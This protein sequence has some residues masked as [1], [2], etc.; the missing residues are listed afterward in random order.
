MHIFRPVCSGSLFWQV[1]FPMSNCRKN[2]LVYL[3]LVEIVLY[4]LYMYSFYNIYIFFLYM[5]I[6]RYIFT[7]IYIY[8]HTPSRS[9]DSTLQV[10]AVCWRF[11]MLG[12]F[13]FHG[14]IYKAGYF[15]SLI[16]ILWW[17]FE[18]SNTFLKMRIDCNPSRL[19]AR[20][21]R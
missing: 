9:A 7:W 10:N 4:I 18:I 14:S 12:Y 3:R 21:H 17:N 6:Y 11:F 19:S 5:H 1:Y 20:C 15:I 16:R 13:I 8:I 2:Y